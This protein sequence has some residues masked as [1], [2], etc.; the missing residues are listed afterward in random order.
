MSARTPPTSRK[1]AQRKP[2][3]P[4]A[5]ASALAQSATDAGVPARLR[6]LLRKAAMALRDRPTAPSAQRF[7]HR[8]FLDAIPDPTLILSRDG[9]ILDANSA[10]QATHGRSRDELI[11]HHVS[12]LNPSLQ[13]DFLAPVLEA[14]DQGQ[15]H[16]AQ[17]VNARAD[18]TR[19]P[20]EVHSAGLHLD[21]R[22]AILAIAREL[23]ARIEAE[24]RHM[25]LADAIDRAI[26]LHDRSGRVLYMNPA[27]VRT[28]GLPVDSHGHPKLDPADWTLIDGSGQVLAPADY[29]LTRALRDGITINSTILGLYQHS[30]QRLG[31]L[32][33]TVVPQFSPGSTHPDGAL[34]LGSDITA[35]QRDKALFARV[36]ELAEIGGWQWDRPSGALYL[37]SESKRILRRRHAP[38]TMAGL[39]A[40]LDEPDRKRLHKT[41]KSIRGDTGFDL[42]LRGH[43]ARAVP[44]WVRMI[45]EPDPFDPGRNRLAGTLQD[46]TESKRAE[47]ALRAQAQTDALT[48]LLNRDA[49]LEHI[50]SALHVRGD[51]DL[52]VLY[53]D[54]DRFKIVND[55]LGHDA[56]DQLLVDV[57][58]RLQ[59]AVG[60]EGVTAR[61]GGDEFLVAC[62]IKADR[63]R[64]QRLA[65][66]IQEA[67]TAPFQL[68]GTDFGV[69]ASIGL[70]HAP[71][72]GRTPKRLIQSADVAMYASKRKRHSGVQAF[73]PAL[74][75]AQQER[76]QIETRLRRALDNGE[77]HLAYQPQVD[78]R[79]GR[80]LHAEALLRW[81]NPELGAVAP[82]RFIDLA[83]NTGDVVRIG[84]WAL[85]QACTQMRR[86]LDQGL[87]IQ[88][89]A[90]NVS[91]RQFVGEDLVASVRGMLEEA[92]LPGH[93][94]ELEIT[95]RVL[96]EDSHDATLVF[97]GLRSLGVR[98]T[99]DDF[100]EG[101]SALNYL[102][103]LPI[104]GIKLSQIFV[105][106]VPGNKSDVAICEAVTGV[107]RSLGLEV[108]AEG[109]ETDAQ[110]DFLLRLGVST[111]QGYLFMPALAPGE[112]AKRVL[113]Q[114]D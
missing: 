110:R 37:T 112:L 87:P 113:A 109:I 20:V 103:R 44:F 43:T 1:P 11:G 40:C 42:D 6:T 91:F 104:H 106:G 107:A 66:Q 13:A 41:L 45:G 84:H 89:I 32:S 108:I 52:A 7:E 30:S 18:S 2:P 28:Y 16:I 35:L 111:G 65:R 102:R 82:E 49:I 99:I 17:T 57:A 61:F 93:A 90:V 54:L 50:R 85:L 60:E 83:E 39:L 55:V 114:Q 15:T 64:P 68:G 26:T 81:C 33:I 46:I 24:A 74:E 72:D 19:F 36:Q 23:G 58:K 75:K 70:A 48:G 29:P 22:D 12:L 59:A 4:G 77:F 100:G 105:R 62:R 95:E 76:L 96:V 71:T 67:F 21:G 38:D 47:E 27:T 51:P 14:I 98:L 63:D 9:I 34:M 97:E 86:W 78:L 79:S 5:L 25:A 53:I 101:Y 80:I 3:D 94:L 92:K 10:S 31:W 88:R 73:T 8:A 56:G 69:S